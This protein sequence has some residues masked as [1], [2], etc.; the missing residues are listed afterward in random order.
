MT[1]ENNTREYIEQVKEEKDL[2]V[3]ID[4]QPT[5]KN[6]INEKV[7][8]ANRNLGIIKRTFPC[9]DKQIFLNLYKTIVRPHLEY[10]SHLI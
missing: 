4:E 1:N 8:V 9:L 6:H 10:A 5:F 7:K 3:L 2:G